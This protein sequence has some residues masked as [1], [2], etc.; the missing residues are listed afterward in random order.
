MSYGSIFR[1]FRDAEDVVPYRFVKDLIMPLAI[2]LLLTNPR[3]CD[4]IFLTGTVK[5]AFSKEAVY[6]A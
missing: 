6:E 1:F 4:I 5:L 2:Y 3:F